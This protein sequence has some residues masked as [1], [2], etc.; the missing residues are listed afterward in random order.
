MVDA[1]K[2]QDEAEMELLEVNPE[3]DEDRVNYI[4]KDYEVESE[5]FSKN[6]RSQ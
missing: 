1:I 6:Y 2:I 4:I 5:W 3:F